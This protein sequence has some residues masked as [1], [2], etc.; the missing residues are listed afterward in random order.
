[1]ARPI[2]HGH[3]RVLDFVFLAMAGACTVGLTLLWFGFSS[4]VA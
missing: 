4:S 2:S 1:M 3:C